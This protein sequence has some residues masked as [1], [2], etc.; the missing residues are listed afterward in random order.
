MHDRRKF[1]RYHLLH[2]LTG[3]IEH[4]EIRHR[5]EIVELSTAGFRFRLRGVSRDAFTAQKSPLDFGEISYKN[6]EIGGFGEIR[7]VRSAGADLLIGFKWDDIHA[8]ASIQKTF[9]IIAELVAQKSAGCVTI[10]NGVV[11]LG[12]HVSSFLAEDIRQSLDPRQPRISL[13]ECTSIDTSGLAML[14]ALEDARTQIGEA[15]SEVQTLLQLYRRQGPA[16]ILPGAHPM[17]LG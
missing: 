9:T 16:S 5:G 4:G 8:D 10:S 11:E 6:E 2:P 14:V 15:G 1:S 12:G 13:R 7:Y 17:F 3:Y